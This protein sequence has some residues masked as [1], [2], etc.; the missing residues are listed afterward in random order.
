MRHFRD[1]SITRKLRL[2]AALTNVVALLIAATA[3]I[4]FELAT[5]R[6]ETTRMLTVLADEIGLHS[7][8]SLSFRDETAARETLAG[9]KADPHVIGGTLFARNRAVFATYARD[10]GARP[11]ATPPD[12]EVE[13]RADSVV[14]TR[15]VMLNGKRIGTVCV[16]SDLKLLRERLL[17]L[18]GIVLA[19]IVAA[20]L[21]TMAFTL[22][23]QRS[24]SRPINTLAATAR[25]I[26]ERKDY[27][28]R[29]RL[30]MSHDEIGQLT[31]AFNQM[32]ESIQEREAAL[33][34]NAQRLEALVKLN[35]MTDATPQQLTDFALEECVRLTR[36]A[37][38]YLAFANRAGEVI[39]LNIW[40]KNG[41]EPGP[42]D[43]GLW[44]VVIAQRR[45]AIVND[46]APPSA[47]A[48]PY[49]VGA[50]HLRRHMDI[51]LL[52]GES[53][54]AVAGV[55]NKETPYD[56]SDVQQATLL[57]QGMWRLTQRRY[58]EEELIKHRDH[59]EDLV[60]ER[61]AE[62]VK[63]NETVKDRE[64]RFRVIFERSTVGKSLTTPDGKLLEVNRAFGD[65]LGY[66]IEEMLQIDFASITH[67]DDL[68][69]SRESV[70]AL[71]ANECATHRMEKRYV[72]KSGNIVW[73][74]VGTTLLRNADG[75]PVYII[76]SITDITEQKR[77][78]ERLGAAMAELARSNK[79]LEQFAY[80]A[81]HDL[82]E[83]LRKVASFTQLL[84][85]RYGDKL[86][87]DA[88]DFIAYAVDGAHRMQRLITD[89]LSYSRV[90]TRGTPFAPVDCEAV[91]EH[92]IGNLELAIKENCAVVTHD[93]LPTVMGDSSQLVQLFQNLIGNAIKFKRP[94]V[95]PEVHVSAKM[96]IG[97]LSLGRN[98]PSG[99]A[100]LTMTNDASQAPM[101]NDP[102]TNDSF[103][104]FS[105]S[106]NG[107]GIDSQYYDQ[108][109]VIFQRLHSRADYPGTGI[110]LA[111]SKKVVE[112]HGGRMWVES[113]P[114]RGSTFF[115]TIP[116]R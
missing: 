66:T 97:H 63:A 31:T 64:A 50:A 16:E 90:S 52:D 81:S 37:T 112:R 7:A 116:R 104:L 92:C 74:Y 78:A 93:Q 84:A 17:S 77:A 33:Q 57:L 86:D 44:N 45:P 114:E 3:Y 42:A 32:L 83:P 15:P 69:K 55:G 95:N 107:I 40:P 53:L 19:A 9:L 59:L 115:F 108:I 72:H 34:L 75:A 94:G 51:P 58:A 105:V 25:S 2:I 102:M 29:A 89:L 1:I 101:T 96:V 88:K 87:S 30:S 43:A 110:G 14:L 98:P 79:E 54:V 80:I 65:M 82:Q 5:S 56:E 113:E 70:R 8:A 46:A 73:T 35:L 21:L 103:W 106:D 61:T 41:S 68:P 47:D 85:E 48:P 22:V 71:L 24:I 67:P 91:V 18:A 100:P 49:P 4:A 109:F 23:L 20:L 111:I 28:V 36:S 60:E 39:A 11:I 10:A 38:G 99:N 13:F 62:V 6:Q 27:S 76:T 12:S 26:S